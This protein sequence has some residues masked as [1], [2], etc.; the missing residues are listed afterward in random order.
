M[1]LP[2]VLIVDDQPD[3]RKLLHMIMDN[4]EWQVVEAADGKEAIE[5]I[6]KHRPELVLLDIMMPGY[7]NGL[8]LLEM[9]KKNKTVTAKIIMVTAKG[10][11][12]DVLK[13]AQMKCDAYVIKPFTQDHLT[14]TIKKVMLEKSDP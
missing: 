2:T 14:D 6:R 12:D 8:E 1:I 10:Q 13:A 9:V 7:P 3:V 11:Y 4:G 5:Q